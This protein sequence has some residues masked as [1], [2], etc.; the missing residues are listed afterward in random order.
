MKDADREG[1]KE[2]FY[3]PEI[4]VPTKVGHPKSEIHSQGFRMFT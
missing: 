4:G 3:N 2:S 1:G